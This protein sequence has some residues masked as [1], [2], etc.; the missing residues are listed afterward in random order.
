MAFALMHGPTGEGVDV[1]KHGTTSD[2][3]QRFRC[4]HPLCESVTCLRTSTYQGL[5]PEGKRRIIEM[6]RTGRGM[7][8][9]ARV[10]PM[11]PSPVMQE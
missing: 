10:L 3:K 7:R 6:S 2:G 4:Q 5:L 8:H 11:S 9:I 1:V